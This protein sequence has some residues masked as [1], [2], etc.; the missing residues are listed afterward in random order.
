MDDLLPLSLRSQAYPASP[1]RKL[2]PYAKAAEA[3]GHKV[4]Y[5]NIGEPNHETPS[6]FFKPIHAYQTPHLPYAPS[7]GHPELLTAIQ[8]YFFQRGFSLELKHIQVTQ[9]A[10]D[11]LLFSLFTIANPGDEIITFEPF[12]P[13]YLAFTA[14]LGLTLVGIPTSMD[15]GYALPSLET[16]ESYVTAKTKAILIS[17][18]SNPTGR[19]YTEEE[20]KR[21][22]AFAQKHHVWIVS[23]ELYHT[24]TFAGKTAT[25][26]LPYQKDYPAIVVI[27]SISKRYAACGARIG[28]LINQ[29]TPFM[30]KIFQLG[31]S[32]LGVPLLDQLGAAALYRLENA[33]LAHLPI[34][35]E[36]RRNKVMDF[37][38][39]YPWI[40]Y[41][42]PE[43]TF[44]LMLSLPI[45]DSNHFCQW[46][47]EHIHLN[48]ERVLITPAENLYVTPGKGKNEVRLALVLEEEQL[49]RA[50]NIL[51]YGL[52]QYMTLFEPLPPSR[53]VHE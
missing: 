13:N 6:A 12:Y 16:M 35:Y 19:I 28:C 31:Q 18:P 39:A 25:T 53:P 34:L 48:G 43:A 51:V 36:A 23:D 27:D 44:Y 21:M 41:V 40:H 22:V 38:S 49:L 32:R 11:A 45:H 2:I 29:H 46:L 9:G 10:T 20:L 14:Q 26:L 30:E 15:Q 24:L 42:K 17:N 33:S 1:I 3:A 4:F 50:M 5:L 8:S 47:I 7:Q 37:L 52:Q